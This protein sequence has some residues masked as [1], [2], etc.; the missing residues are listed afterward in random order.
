[1]SKEGKLEAVGKVRTFKKALQALIDVATEA[2]LDD[3][4]EIAI[5]H[6]ENMEDATT[7]KNAVAALYPHTKIHI[8]PLSLVVS[9]HVGEGTI[10]LT[11]IKTK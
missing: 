11:W 10:G 3:T 8:L 2:Q 4:Y 5:M 7:L 9:V 1:M 6:M